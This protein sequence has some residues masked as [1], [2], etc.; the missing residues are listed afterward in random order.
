MVSDVPVGAFLSGGIDSSLLVA[1]MA[2]QTS[3]Q[4]KTFSIGFGSEGS[5]I[6]ETEDAA[7]IARF[8]GTEHSR[9]EISGTMVRDR[10]CHIVSALDQPSVDGVNSYLV[11]MAA[12]QAVSVAI[13][14]TGGDELFAGYPWFLNMYRAAQADGMLD[15]ALHYAREYQV[16]HV[17]EVFGLLTPD[18]LTG[19]NGDTFLKYYAHLP[20]ELTD[21]TPL[22]RVS[23]LCLRG[24][25]QNQLLRDIDA[26]SMAH[27]LEV[28]V[29][30]LD[31]VLAD[32]AL[33]LPLHAKLNPDIASLD[34]YAATYRQ[35]GVKRVLVEIGK[36][37]LPPHMDM[38][39]KRGF[40][41][42]FTSWMKNELRDI[43]EE[44]LSAKS[45]K[46]RGIFIP[47]EI[48]KLKNELLS[49]GASWPQVWL[50]MMMEMWCRTALDDSS[51]YVGNHV[52]IIECNNGKLNIEEH[53]VVNPRGVLQLH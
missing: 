23:A 2:R 44:M 53:N 46:E 52:E 9:V 14:G 35:T 8:I 7:R 28:R 37:F 51:E 38:Q 19:F 50:P 33:S 5:G 17:N 31:P 36:D 42:P 26:V 16:F 41:M 48:K 25:T 43:V 21:A 13:S 1:M 29:P 30:F 40:G 15:F 11:S 22:E 20:D 10:I 34:P 39:P 12:K 18:I 4:V 47:H 49:G 3:H 45:V 32:I 27:S 24:Y 6:D